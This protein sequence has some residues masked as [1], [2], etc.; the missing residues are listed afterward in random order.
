MRVPSRPGVHAGAPMRGTLS[1]MCAR[2][3]QVWL[4]RG[5]DPDC[6]YTVIRSR[7]LY[8]PCHD[9]D[10]SYKLTVLIR[11]KHVFLPGCSDTTVRPS[12]PCY[13]FPKRCACLMQVSQLGSSLGSSLAVEW[14]QCHHMQR[15]A[16]CRNTNPG[17][18]CTGCQPLNPRGLCLGHIYGRDI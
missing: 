14:E 4:V 18:R 2:C 12:V 1:L 6:Y 3:C 9:A 17:C 10:T 7:A 8:I 5:R 13:P 15:P 16:L 11:Y